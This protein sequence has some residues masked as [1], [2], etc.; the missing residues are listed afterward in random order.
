MTHDSSLIQCATVFSS[1]FPLYLMFAALLQMKRLTSLATFSISSSATHC[2]SAVSTLPYL[3]LVFP[4]PCSLLPSSP[5]WPALS[6]LAGGTDFDKDWQQL[7][8]FTFSHSCF[9]SCIILFAESTAFFLQL[10]THNLRVRFYI[11]V[12]SCLSNCMPSC[13]GKECAC[14]SC[15]ANIK[16]KKQTKKN[17]EHIPNS[18]VPKTKPSNPQKRW[19]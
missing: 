12:T 18:H 16:K 14:V 5:H 15:S 17:T 6:I 19:H 8:A 7:L 9:S 4:S 10:L 2:F 13:S 11:L 1:S 3:P